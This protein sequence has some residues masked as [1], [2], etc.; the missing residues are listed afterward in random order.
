MT[1]RIT[2]DRAG[3]LAVLMLRAKKAQSEFSAVGSS[4]K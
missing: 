1:W 4:R 3:V 2:P